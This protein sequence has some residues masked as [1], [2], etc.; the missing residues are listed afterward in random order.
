MAVWDHLRR[1]GLE[2]LATGARHAI[3]VFLASGQMTVWDHLRRV[4]LEHLA[5]LFE[6][7]GYPRKADLAGLGVDDV[8]AW[9]MDLKTDE[10][11]KHE[12]PRFG[13]TKP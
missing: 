5:P 10:V 6:H 13:S 9:S 4:G 11:R 1:V 12:T 8:K 7:H 2:H 3:P